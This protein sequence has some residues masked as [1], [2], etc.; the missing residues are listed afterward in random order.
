MNVPDANV[1]VLVGQMEVALVV[2]GLDVTG[3]AA[4]EIL[5]AAV[6]REV[7]VVAGKL[8]DLDSPLPC[9]GTASLSNVE[10]QSIALIR[11]IDIHWIEKNREFERK[12]KYLEKCL[13]C[14]PVFIPQ[15]T[16]VLTDPGAVTEN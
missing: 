7:V 15:M 10:A 2:E 16:G 5:Q 14:S 3:G 4:I 1:L 12:N 6:G 13:L 8:S 11:G 9:G